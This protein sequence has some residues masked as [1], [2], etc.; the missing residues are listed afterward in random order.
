MTD[1]I[2]DFLSRGRNGILSRKSSIDVPASKMKRRL[3][4]ILVS[5][6]F[7]A[8]FTES[9]APRLPGVLP[10]V[11]SLTL[12]WDP[13][14]RPAISG[15]RRVSR[16]GQRTYVGVGELPKV[17]NGMGTAIVST[18]KGV[19]TDRQARKLGLGGE[20]ICEVW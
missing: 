7:I 11:L 4:E 18:S 1:P 19:M 20:V 9:A 2:S 10:G 17:R 13:Q 15:I 16:P 5:E 12:R 6:G 8:G 3:A 14:N